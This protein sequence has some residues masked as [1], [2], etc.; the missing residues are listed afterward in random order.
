VIIDVSGTKYE[1]IRNIA[2][3]RYVFQNHFKGEFLSFEKRLIHL[4]VLIFRDPITF[5]LKLK[6]K[7]NV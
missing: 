7:L 1:L 6:R 4:V 3:D 2:N 5:F